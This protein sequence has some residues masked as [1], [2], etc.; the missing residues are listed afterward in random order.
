MFDVLAV[1]VSPTWAVP[2]MVGRPVG[3]LFSAAGVPLASVEAGLSPSSLVAM[4]LTAYSTPPVSPVMVWVV[5]VTVVWETSAAVSQLSAASF[6]CTLYPVTAEP[7]LDDGACQ[8]AS[9]SWTWS[10]LGHGQ[11]LGGGGHRRQPPLLWRCW[12][13]SL[14]CPGRR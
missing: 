1:R 4:T 10:P 8:D 6:H 5:P 9:S 3:A 12:S 14:R 7:P 11:A 2:L 13:A